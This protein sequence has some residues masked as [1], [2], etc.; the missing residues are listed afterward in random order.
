MDLSFFTSSLSVVLV[1]GLVVFI[2]ELGHFLAA[3]YY[4]I[5]V[6]RFSIGFGPELF[7]W[8]DSKG[9][10]W[11]MSLLPL[12][13]YVM[14]L[15]DADVS[16]NTVDHSIKDEDKNKCI[17]YRSPWQR[18]VV[19]VWGPLA[20]YLLAML[21][22]FIVFFSYGKPGSSNVIF[23]FSTDSPAKEAGLMIG[24]TIQSINGT[25]IKNFVDFQ[26]TMKELKAPEVTLEILRSETETR[27][28]SFIA[29]EMKGSY[30]I[31]VST[32]QSE[33]GQLG[34]SLWSAFVAP[35][36]ISYETMK[37]LSYMIAN[38]KSDGLGGPVAIIKTIA[39]SAKE[40]LM[41]LLFYTA[42]LS[43]SL[44][45]FNLLPIPTLDG[46]HILFCLIEII[47]GR[48]VKEKVQEWI[49]M[50]GLSFLLILF[51]FV[52]YKDVFLK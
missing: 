33:K 41:Q 13:G 32:G 18:I 51:L 24:D 36:K 44:G 4:G 27:T 22:F 38:A 12:G 50:I 45:F 28:L 23:L 21:V 35:F 6:S 42:M 20:N 15:G 17:R 47:R 31:G 8:T 48:P 1:F 10:R 26:N 9:T 25:P 37:A 43:T 49:F 5:A 40:G 3:R 14:F 19:N 29:K 16:S 34:D 7:G 11:K 30:I 2:H 52:T 46:G 39:S